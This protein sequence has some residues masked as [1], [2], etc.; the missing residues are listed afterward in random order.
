MGRGRQLRLRG[1][2]LHDATGDSSLADA[3]EEGA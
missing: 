2:L 1:R 3:L